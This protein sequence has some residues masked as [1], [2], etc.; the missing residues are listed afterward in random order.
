[1]MSFELILK[2]FVV[3]DAA[4]PV[5][6]PTPVGPRD[7]RRYL[8]AA[9]AGAVPCMVLAVYYL[10]LRM[11]A[12]LAVAFVAG[13]LVELTFALV[14]KKPMTGGSLVFALLLTLILPPAIPLWMVA[15]GSA[16]GTFFGKEVFGGTG[17]HIFSPV[18]LGKAFLVLSY[19]TTVTGTHFG[20]MP[21]ANPADAWMACSAVILLGAVAMMVAHRENLHVFA[22][23]LFS[24]GCT[25]TAMSAA[26]NLPYGSLLELFVADGFLFCVCFLV[27]DPAVAPHGKASRLLYG[28]LIGTLAV[29]MRCFADPTDAMMSAALVGSLF[30]PLLDVTNRIGSTREEG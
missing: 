27:C 28:M 10:G 8:V 14:R 22:G 11:L 23:L 30:A 5:A 25:A 9:L 2:R 6:G 13:A 1:M 12:M 20:S 3:P 18:L 26:G 19:P 21:G 7:M 16:F 29:L 17:H 15:A 24:A 4:H